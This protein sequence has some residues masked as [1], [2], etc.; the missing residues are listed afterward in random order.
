MQAFNN[1]IRAPFKIFYG[2]DPNK[3]HR[4]RIKLDCGSVEECLTYGEPP[5][6]CPMRDTLT[7]VPLPLG[8]RLCKS[9]AAGPAPYR[10]I[11]D[12]L[13]RSEVIFPPDPVEPKYDLAPGIWQLMRKDYERTVAYWTVKL[14]CSH[15]TKVVTDLGWRPGDEPRTTAERQREMLEENEADRLLNPEPD[16]EEQMIRDHLRRMLNDGWPS[17]SPEAQCS[18]CSYARWIVGYQSLDWLVPR[19]KP[20]NPRPPKRELLTNRLN[21]LEADAAELRR[22]LEQLP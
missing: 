14:S 19:P 20:P 1:G 8:Q 7:G 5:N 11:D 6:K 13:E 10:T 3:L 12:W 9:H 16:V 22:E 4:W 2:H 21:K 15:Q 18:T 17:P